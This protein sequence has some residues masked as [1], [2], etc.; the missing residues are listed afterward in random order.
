MQGTKQHLELLS[1]IPA[2]P[3]I[4]ARRRVNNSYAGFGSY[5][6]LWPVS[7]RQS[8]P[9]PWSLP[10]SAGGRWTAGWWAWQSPSLCRESEGVKAKRVE[11]TLQF[12]HP[13]WI[14]LNTKQE[15]SNLHQDPV[16]GLCVVL[17][18][19]HDHLTSFHDHSGVPVERFLCLSTVDVHI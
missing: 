11:L 17:K 18:D 4:P 3:K 13:N 16:P 10:G 19:F 12:S 14:K 7:P 8:W 6:I 15:V 1:T 5:H 9:R 2:S